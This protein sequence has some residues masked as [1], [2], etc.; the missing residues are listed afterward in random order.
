MAWRREAQLNL[1]GAEDEEEV[2]R[3]PQPRCREHGFLITECAPCC[4]T[5]AMFAEENNLDFSDTETA[6]LH[7]QRIHKHAVRNLYA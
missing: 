3:S 4:E 2:I 1:Q 5:L 7:G 6:D